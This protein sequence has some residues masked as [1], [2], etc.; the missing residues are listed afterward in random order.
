[1]VEVVAVRDLLDPDLDVLLGAEAPLFDADL[2]LLVQ[3][4]EVQ[5]E[6]A[7]RAHELHR[8][9]DEAEAERAAP[10]RSSHRQRLAFSAASRS[11]PCSG[12]S[13][14]ARSISSPLALRLIR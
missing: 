5:V 9:V 2:V 4:M 11:S 14:A 8:H 10:Q 3:L 13:C 1:A 7:H 12:S 6:V